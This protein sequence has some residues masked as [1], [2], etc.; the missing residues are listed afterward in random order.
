MESSTR[1]YIAAEVRAELGRQ[2]KTG[3]EVAEVLGRLRGK[4]AVSRQSAS[5]KLRGAV[6]LT[7]HELVALAQWLEV[8]VTQFLPERV[9]A[10]P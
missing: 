8:P 3:S 2:R 6:A 9:E 10:A 7:P 1:R 5:A 4:P